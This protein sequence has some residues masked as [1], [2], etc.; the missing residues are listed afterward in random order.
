MFV[1]VVVFVPVR[2]FA[3]GILFMFMITF[4]SVVMVSYAPVVV[5]KPENSVCIVDNTCTWDS[6]YTC[7]IVC[8]VGNMFER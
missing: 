6:L 7:C 2:M 8:T 5:F 1:P 4:A 3:P